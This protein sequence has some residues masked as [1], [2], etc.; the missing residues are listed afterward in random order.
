VNL[1]DSSKKYFDQIEYNLEKN[2]YE[3]KQ[4]YELKLSQMILRHKDEIHNSINP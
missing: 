3:I 4:N 2:I 1:E